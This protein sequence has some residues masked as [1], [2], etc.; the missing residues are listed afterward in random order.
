LQFAGVPG[1]YLGGGLTLHSGGATR[2]PRPAGVHA[3]FTFSVTGHRP[4]PDDD[5]WVE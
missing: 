3:G 4:E 2:R 5:A 1:G